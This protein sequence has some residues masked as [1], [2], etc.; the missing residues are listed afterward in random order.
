MLHGHRLLG[1]SRSLG[2]INTPTL[3]IGGLQGSGTPVNPHV[4]T[5]AAVTHRSKLEVLDGAH[6]A[7]FEQADKAVRPIRRHATT[8]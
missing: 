6:L 4:K 3:V 2:R 8:R 7:I 1:R 5:L